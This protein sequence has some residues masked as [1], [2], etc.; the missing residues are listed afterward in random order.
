MSYEMR[1]IR[2][3]DLSLY[4]YLKEVVLIDFIELDEYAQLTLD[5]KLSSTTNDADPSTNILV[6]A[7]ETD[8][9][10][11]P[12]SRGRGWVYF[13]TVSG[14]D[15]MDPC[16][17]YTVVSGT[18]ADGVPVMGTPEQSYMVTVYDSNLNVVSGTLYMIDYVDGRIVTDDPNLDLAFVTYHW[19]YVSMVDEWSLLQAAEPPVVVV[20]IHGTNKE[21]YQLGAGKKVIRKVE[22]HVFASSA[23]E[24]KDL[25][26]TLYD[27]LYLKSCP[28]YDFPLGD[29][30]DYDGTFYGRKDNPNKLTS[31]FD[32][33][34]NKNIIGNLKFL[35]I[36][37]RNVGLPPIL[38]RNREEVMSD[39]NAYRAKIS[40]DLVSY[41][42]S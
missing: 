33:T 28:L 42:Y 18:R 8:A 24:R 35:N 7:T 13:D 34:S 36:T 5:P 1:S 30:L 23:A 25:L 41:T 14:T 21:G 2:K 17:P 9:L 37:A 11:N 29:V 22:L 12:I 38:S 10:P 4:H 19:Y 31:L 32:R 16:E 15:L 27:G 40:F 6:Y 26:D 20:D 39:L 3:E